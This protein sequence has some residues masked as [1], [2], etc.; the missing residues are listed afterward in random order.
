MTMSNIIENYIENNH[1]GKH[2]GMEFKI[3]VPGHIEYYLNPAVQLEAMEGM[4]HGGAIAGFMDGILGVAALS[5]VEDQNKLVATIEFKIN[6]LKPIFTNQELIGTGKV[7]H[8]GKSTIVVE[9]K[10]MCGMELKVCA[11]G[12][13]KAY[14]KDNK[15]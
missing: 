14:H 15:K 5:A 4:I 12:T 2:L 3:I 7:L 8:L 13:F 11:L 10:I 6:Y 1:F 9:G